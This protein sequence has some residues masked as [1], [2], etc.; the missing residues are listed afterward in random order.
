MLL[1]AAPDVRAQIEATPSLHPRRPPRSSPIDA[2]V[3][4]SADID[5]IAGLLSLRE[6]HAFAI[7]ATGRVHR[8]LAAN[9]VFDALDRHL[10]PRRSLPL[11]EAVE[12]KDARGDALG[13]RLIAFPVPGKVPLYLEQSD[14]PL[15]L[16]G[17]EPEDVVGLHLSDGERGFF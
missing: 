14:D 8:V 2:V 4:S 12:L 15:G 17:T 5:H 9:A 16:H 7:Y 11:E 6:R 3:L 1:D 10:V 13:L